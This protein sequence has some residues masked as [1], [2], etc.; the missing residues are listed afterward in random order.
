[1]M[2][3]RRNADSWRYDGELTMCKTIK[4]R[5]RFKADPATV[6][7]LLA[8]SRKHS[9]ITGRRASIS[10]KIGGTFSMGKPRRFSS[11]SR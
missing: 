2:A 8:D 11:R 5:V 3:C 7:D 6:Y 1:M 9:A 10:R 4:Q